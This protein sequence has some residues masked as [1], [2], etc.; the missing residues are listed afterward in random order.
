MLPRALLPVVSSCSAKSTSITFERDDAWWAR[1][2]P[3][4][5][6]QSRGAPCGRPLGINCHPERS[7]GSGKARGFPD[8]QPSSPNPGSFA[9]EVDASWATLVVARQ[10]GNTGKTVIQ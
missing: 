5:R 2:R 3:W 10:H 4:L 8:G 6:Q 7:E 9:A 1:E